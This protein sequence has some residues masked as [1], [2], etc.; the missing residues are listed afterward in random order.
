MSKLAVKDGDKYVGISS[1]FFK[2]DDLGL[3]IPKPS[4]QYQKPKSPITTNE[5]KNEPIKETQ[6]K[7][8]V[9][10]PEI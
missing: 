9:N 7:S 6:Q 4:I 1:Y 5:I 3:P 2:Y 8:V 10:K